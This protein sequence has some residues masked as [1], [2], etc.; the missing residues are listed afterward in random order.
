MALQP[1]LEDGY[2]RVVQLQLERK[3][4]VLGEWYGKTA[5]QAASGGGLLDGGWECGTRVSIESME[6]STNT[7]SL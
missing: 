5:L 7:Y 2:L 3:V 6:S 4:T 1:A